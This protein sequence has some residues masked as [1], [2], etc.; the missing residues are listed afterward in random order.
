MSR[1]GGTGTSPMACSQSRRHVCEGH[2]LR[3]TVSPFYLQGKLIR[4]PIM[5]SEGFRFVGSRSAG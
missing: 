2:T 5:G 4:C 1:N 3:S